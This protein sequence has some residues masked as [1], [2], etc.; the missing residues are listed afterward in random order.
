MVKSDEPKIEAQIKDE[1]PSNTV[2]EPK[3]PSKIVEDKAPDSPAKA[4]SEKSASSKR[5][6]DLKSEAKIEARIDRVN[7]SISKLQPLDVN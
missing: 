3:E 7:C 1:M 4:N 5:R 6:R 2:A